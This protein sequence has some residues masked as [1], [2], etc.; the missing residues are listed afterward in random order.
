MLAVFPCIIQGY[1][2]HKYSEEYRDLEGK[3]QLEWYGEKYFNKYIKGT[4]KEEKNE[5]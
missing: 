1:Y 2:L 3:T 5:K 4:N